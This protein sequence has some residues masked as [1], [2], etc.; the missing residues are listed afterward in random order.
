[1]AAG[2]PIAKKLFLALTAAFAWFALI[3]QFYINVNSKAAPVPEIVTR[4]FSYF[5]IDTNLLVAL[6]CSFTLL[7]KNSK[8]GNFFSKQSTQAAIT[9]YILI[10][11]IVYNTILRFIWS[12]QGLQ[13]IV[14]EILHVVTPVLFLVYWFLFVSKDKLEWKYAFSWMIYPLIYGSFVLIRGYLSATQFYP[15]PFIDISKLGINKGIINTI[16]FTVIFFVASILFI[17]IGKFIHGKN[18]SLSQNSIR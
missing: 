2:N 11:G 9:V 8:P 16:G 5:T 1:M 4:Y 17:G 12:P 13:M 3:A 18:N 10:V 7:F 14:D 6:S 15:Y